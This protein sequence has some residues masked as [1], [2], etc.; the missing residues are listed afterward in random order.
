MIAAALGL[1]EYTFVS[2]P[3][4][5]HAR[6]RLVLPVASERWKISGDLPGHAPCKLFIQ[7]RCTCRW[8]EL[9]FVSTQRS[10]RALLP[11]TGICCGGTLLS[12]LCALSP[13]SHVAPACHCQWCQCNNFVCARLCVTAQYHC[14]RGARI[15]SNLMLHL[16]PVNRYTVIRPSQLVVPKCISCYLESSQH[17]FSLQ[18]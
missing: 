4:T 18:M 7:P 2:L 14:C 15:V 3:G 13:G 17:V 11:L 12:N 8:F 5:R 1:A 16:Q 6:Q 10:S 9:A